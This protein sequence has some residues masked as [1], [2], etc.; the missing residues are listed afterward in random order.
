MHVA[1]CTVLRVCACAL[2]QLRFGFEIK[3]TEQK[4][5]S[6]GGNLKDVHQGMDT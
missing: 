2:I 1:G 5:E 4:S 6:K 3:K